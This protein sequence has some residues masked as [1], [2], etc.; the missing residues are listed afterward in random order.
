MIRSIY[1]I[2]IQNFLSL[3]LNWGIKIYRFISSNPFYSNGIICV[4]VKLSDNKVRIVLKF[5]FFIF[6]FFI[7]RQCV[8]ICFLFISPIFSDMQMMLVNRNDIMKVISFLHR[9][10]CNSYAVFNFINCFLFSLALMIFLFISQILNRWISIM[11][12]EVIEKTSAIEK[13][14]R[15]INVRVLH[16]DETV[17]NFNLPVSTFLHK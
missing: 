10:M 5:V 17:H 4:R 6:V 3:C 7:L 13:K 15:T 9:I 8:L 2:N 16:L 1:N 14:V 12:V 11:T